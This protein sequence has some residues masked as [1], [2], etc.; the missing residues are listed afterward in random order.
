MARIRTIKPEI[1]SSAQFVECSTNARLLFIGL[2][3]F[4]DDFG[5]HPA[6]LSR[7]KME[8]FP[9]DSLSEKKL[10]AM[11]Q[12][13]R[14]AKDQDGIPLVG[15]FTQDG[16]RY[17]VVTGFSRHQKVERRTQR[18][19]K[20]PPDLVKF[21]EPSPNGRRHIDDQS[22]PET[23]RDETRRRETKGR[24]TKGVRLVSSV[25]EG[26]GERGET[27]PQVRPPPSPI[28]P[29]DFAAIHADCVRVN[30]TVPL[31][32]DRDRDL[33]IRAAILARY[34]FTLG[35]L[36][37]CAES[38]PENRPRNP[39]KYF[40]GALRTAAEEK[41]GVSHGKFNELLDGI[42]IP[43]ELQKTKTGADRE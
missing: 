12:E 1:W 35:W 26:R 41:F 27:T 15:E 30:Q 39:G 38:L 17:W 34:T 42:K 13:L 43:P 22:P 25:M 18:Y 11:V 3:N 31:G 36:S 10:A 5:V 33:I 40:H 21:V 37:S 20:P 7:L 2:W 6:S 32:N 4:C 28:P 23:R 8:V 16:K 29:E 19:P 24:E 14:D 9:G